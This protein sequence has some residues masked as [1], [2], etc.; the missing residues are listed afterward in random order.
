MKAIADHL[1]ISQQGIFPDK[2]MVQK[3]HAIV[4]CFLIHFSIT[5]Q[6]EYVR[7]QQGQHTRHALAQALQNVIEP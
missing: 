7:K 2:I 5:R 4:A 6:Y 1:Q 3:K